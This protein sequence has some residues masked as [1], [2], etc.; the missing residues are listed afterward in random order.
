MVYKVL[1][2]IQKDIGRTS[3]Y[4]EHVK[5]INNDEQ[6]DLILRN[7]ISILEP[8][9]QHIRDIVMGI[10]SS[11][12]L[13]MELETNYV[14]FKYFLEVAVSFTEPEDQELRQR[15][16]NCFL[17][18]RHYMLTFEKK[19]VDFTDYAEIKKTL[20]E[21]EDICKKYAYTRT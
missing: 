4:W 10:G 5:T 17:I 12:K 2:S 19:I 6:W 15:L 13:R 3:P 16:I 7:E 14:D 11:F 20:E 1:W 21:K 9:G 8:F 18:N